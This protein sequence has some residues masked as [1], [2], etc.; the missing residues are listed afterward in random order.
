[1]VEIVDELPAQHW[2]P[3]LWLCNAN[4]FYGYLAQTYSRSGTSINLFE[5]GLGSYRG[6]MDPPF[7]RESAGRRMHQLSVSVRSVVVNPNLGTKRKARRVAHHAARFLAETGPGRRLNSALVPQ[8]PAFDTP[9][10]V[11]DRAVMAFPDLVDPTL[12]RA[13]RLE[14]LEMDP[15]KAE[16]AARE[17]QDGEVSFSEPLF[18]SQRYGV[19]YAPWTEAIARSLQARGIDAIALKHHPRETDRERADLTLA[20]LDAG[21]TVR[22][23]PAFDKWTAESLIV[24][25][26]PRQVV[27]ITSSTLVYRPYTPWPI[28]YASIG[29][30][31]LDLLKND[32]RVHRGSL[33]HLDGDLRLFDRVYARLDQG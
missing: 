1:M 7:V 22:A 31:V 21:L 5:E 28:S 2:A 27:G 8:A 26:R 6:R 15:D 24:E 14:R 13:A 19:P 12:V 4:S 16:I 32:P 9:W 10:T 20:L 18:L 3:R 17:A 23:D 29:R 30:E 33:V 25:A 11:F